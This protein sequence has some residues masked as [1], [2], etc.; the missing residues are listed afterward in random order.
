MNNLA[1]LLKQRLDSSQTPLYRE[2]V[3]N[4]WRSFSGQ[5]I[6]GMAAR[7]QQAFRREGFQ[8]GDRVALCLKN[9][10]NWVAA[11][12]AGLGMGLVIVPLYVNDNAANIAW[13]V[14]DSEA[15]LL[16][17]QNTR[18]LDAL[19]RVNNQLPTIICIEADSQVNTLEKWLPAAG[20]EF[21]ID[22]VEPESLATIVYTSGTTGPPKGVKL[23]HGNILSNV[24]AVNK[25]V[26]LHA[27]DRVLSVLPLSHMFER[28]C[29]Y[30]LTLY[31][32]V[33]VIF[34]RGIQ[35]LAEDLATQQ[36]SILITV[37]RVLERFKARIEDKLAASFFK[38]LLY[39]LT[40]RF[41]WRVYQQRASGLERL[42][43]GLLK[44][45]V[46]GALLARLDPKLRM[47]VVGGAALDRRVGRTFIGL[48]LRITQGYG[49]TETSPVIAGNREGDTDVASVGAPLEN[50]EVRVNQAGELLVRGPSVMLGYWRKPQA[51]R[52]VLDEEGWFNTGDQVDIRNGKIYIKGRTKDILVL[53]NGE[54][55][56]PQEVEAAIL[57]DDVFEQVMLVG[58]GRPFLTLLAVTQ[59]ADA[60]KLVRRANEKLKIFPRYIRVHRVIPLKEPWT[61]ENAL[62]TT[63]L[64]VKRKQVSEKFN[65]EIEK[66]YGAAR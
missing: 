57:S 44:K 45:W 31:A 30:Y 7:W 13:C 47:V 20:D 3:G 61:I 62:L 35:Q 15:K 8:K 52:E 38:R 40:V 10:T 51:T 33:Q 23:S 19:R 46:A 24:H 9:S 14:T 39:A 5:D 49:L 21:R 53:S 48:G 22:E 32:G 64:K 55:V 65:S 41:G 34:A 12:M 27:S 11:D 59:E 6:A 54:K 1:S 43:Y 16:V 17:L 28:T 63:T 26:A 50:V 4:G 66:T 56:P 25:A 18:M 2:F 42:V 29:G 37:P 60:N 36:P 58:E